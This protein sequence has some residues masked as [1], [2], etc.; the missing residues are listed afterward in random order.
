MSLTQINSIQTLHEYLYAAI[1]LEHATIPT[2]LTTLYSIH[3][4]TNLDAVQVLRVIAV[5]EM[6][7]MTLSANMLNAVGGKVDLT[8]PGFVP[9][10]PTYL[11]NGETDFEVSLQKFSP[12]A[13]E[14][15]LKIERPAK[16]ESEEKRFVKRARHAKHL[17]PTFKSET[18]EYMHFYSIGEF[19]HFIELGMEHLCR[20]FGEAKVFI[21]DPSRQITPEY[22]YSGGGEISGVVAAS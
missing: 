22:Y 10:F 5:E 6:L 17:L 16:L 15:F 13:L 8:Q 21:G 18:G 20:E 7:H 2:Y 14:T 9:N 4:G 12:D 1:Q 3:P 19:Y 11:P